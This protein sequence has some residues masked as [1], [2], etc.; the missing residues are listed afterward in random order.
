M[1][2]AAELWR[3]PIA[4]SGETLSLP[5]PDLVQV[6]EGSVGRASAW[7]CMEAAGQHG[8]K[9]IRAKRRRRYGKSRLWMREACGRNYIPVRTRRIAKSKILYIEK[10]FPTPMMYLVMRVCVYIY[11][12]PILVIW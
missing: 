8:R 6:D 9:K 12:Y 10:L 1:A 5:S 3:D 7:R 11:M 4:S 2:A